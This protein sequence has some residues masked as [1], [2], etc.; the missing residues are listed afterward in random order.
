MDSESLTNLLSQVQTIAEKYDAIFTLTGEKFNIFQ[1]L[2]LTS[3]ENK[4]SALLAELLNPN[5]NHGKKDFFLKLFIEE[6]LN[7]ISEVDN[8]DKH[9]SLLKEFKT[10][11]AK[12]ITEKSIGVINGEIGGRI[13]LYI[14][15]ETATIIIENKIY[16]KDQDAQLR[17]YYNYNKKALIIYL[18]LDGKN[19]ED[20]TTKNNDN[21]FDIVYP[22]CISY[23]LSI[24][25]WLEACRKE[26]VNQPILR[27]TLLQYIY[28]LKHL[29]HQTMN[30]NMKN[31]IV[32]AIVKKPQ[33]ISSAEQIFNN[34][35]KVKAKIIS[36]LRVEIIK[37]AD[38]LNLNYDIDGNIGEP[39]S[40][41]WFFKKDWCYCIYFYF[42]KKYDELL[43]GIDHIN[44]DN[45]CPENIVAKLK[46]Y[47]QDFDFGNKLPYPN[48]IWVSRFPEWE[49]AA[50]SDVKEKIPLAIENKTKAIL[51]KLEG[52]K[53]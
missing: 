14:Q 20:C 28:L 30:E 42:E 7:E 37:I 4:H 47:L 2:G 43:I 48:W 22:L 31:E 13:D 11:N 3:N 35:D 39:E 50:W 45:K 33:F 26:T 19:A 21:P 38:K 32:E 46:E 6:L 23:A 15:S 24:L 25:N 12:V 18:T 53:I 34:W 36:D 16:A 9:T 27:E 49:A 10:E 52:F 8:F 29:T 51:D 40:G 1:I 5:G 41:F 44:Y 17:R